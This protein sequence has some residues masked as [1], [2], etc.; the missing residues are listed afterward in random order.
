MGGETEEDGGDRHRMLTDTDSLSILPQH[1]HFSFLF[2]LTCGHRLLLSA[3]TG[4]SEAAGEHGH[5]PGVVG[6]QSG[7]RQVLPGQSEC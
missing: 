3:F 6:D 5:L 2:F 4:A 1:T 7:R